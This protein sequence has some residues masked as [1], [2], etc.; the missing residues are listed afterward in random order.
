MV[1][2]RKNKGTLYM[3]VL[4][5]FA[6]NESRIDLSRCGLEKKKKNART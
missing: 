1:Q 2:L 5:S 6:L 4:K 3:H